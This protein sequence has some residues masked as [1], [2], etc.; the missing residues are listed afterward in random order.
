LSGLS[1]TQQIISKKH[2]VLHSYRLKVFHQ[3]LDAISDGVLKKLHSFFFFSSTQIAFAGADLLE[4]RQEDEH[5]GIPEAKRVGR[6][7]ARRNPEDE[8]VKSG[9]QAAG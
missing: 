4:R 6:K 1:L 8:P 3:R 2:Y 5:P 9:L 7:S